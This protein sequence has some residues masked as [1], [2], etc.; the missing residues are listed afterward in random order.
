MGR[1]PAE[2]DGKR[3]EEVNLGAK[4]RQLREMAG[5]TRERLSLEIGYSADY[6]YKIE[7]GKRRPSFNFIA[8]VSEFFKIPIANLLESERAGA[9]EYDPP[10]DVKQ[11][12]KEK[13][14]TYN[15][16]PVTEEE[17]KRL[18]EII[19]NALELARAARRGDTR[20]SGE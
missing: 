11:I 8:E 14:L 5:L 15:G 18:S 6:L 1:A 20:D 16:E 12:L 10:L 7:S 13:N 19:K 4:L 17:R 9:T 2:A 3:G